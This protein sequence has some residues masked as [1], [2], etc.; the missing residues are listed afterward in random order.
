MITY[1]PISAERLSAIRDATKEDDKLQRVIKL[2]LSGWPKNKRDIALDI[3]HY[4]AFQDELSFQDGVVFRGERAVIPD[5]LIADLTCRI[6]SSHLGV[7][8]YLRRARECVYW[9]GMNEQIKTFISKC[10]ICRSVDPKQQKETLRPH[11]VSYRPWSKVGTDLYLWHNKDYMVTVCY[12]SNF[13][14]VDYLPDTKST[15][16]IHK[17]KAH[18]ARQGIPDVLISDNGPQYS[19]QEFKTFSQK[20]EFEHRTSSPGYPQSNGKAESAVKTAKRLMQ[21]ASAAEQDPYLAILDHRNTPSQGLDTSPAQRLLSRTRTLL[22]KKKSLLEP[23]VT[24]NKQ[25]LINN[26]QRQEKYYNRTARDLDCLK[27]G[28]S[29]RVQPFDPCK[30]W[31]PAEVIRTVSPRSYEVELESGGVLRRNRHHL[32]RNHGP[33]TPSTHTGTRTESQ[34]V[35][36]AERGDNT[37][38]TT[39]SGRQVKTPSYLKDYCK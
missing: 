37:I 8:G 7:E 10:D 22:P 24:N 35:V 1:L 34:T 31:R 14:E 36:T 28:D 16:V 29:V 26:R 20:W 6:H 13:W 2:I 27:E 3:Q 38:V 4:F 15:T 5:T 32:R 21:K 9:Q 18:F 11:D 17:L 12:Y 25:G 30:I 23:K 39:R 19:S 33:P